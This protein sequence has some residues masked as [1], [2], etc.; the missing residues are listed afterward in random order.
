MPE[1]P[2]VVVAVNPDRRL[3]VVHVH[4]F[5]HAVVSHGDGHR[6]N[7]GDQLCGDLCTEGQ[8]VLQN[9]SSGENFRAHNYLVNCSSKDAHT[10]AR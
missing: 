6:L 8:T 3:G 10:F 7:V 5:H 1:R 9:V 2:G 4:G